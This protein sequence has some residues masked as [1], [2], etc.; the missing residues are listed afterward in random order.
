MV[1]KKDRKG[2]YVGDKVIY[3][4]EVY[5]VTDN[6]GLNNLWGGKDGIT[7]KKDIPDKEIK[8]LYWEDDGKSVKEIIKLMKKGKY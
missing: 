4:K 5:T 8:T 3:N 2:I 1:K 7:S 6:R